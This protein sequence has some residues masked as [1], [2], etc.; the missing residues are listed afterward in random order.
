MRMN[1]E[2]AGQLHSNTIAVQDAQ[3]AHIWKLEKQVDGMGSVI[4]EMRKRQDTM[5]MVLEEC[6]HQSVMCQALLTHY[7]ESHWV[8]IGALLEQIG[9]RST[10]GL[11]PAAPHY[12]NLHDVKPIIM[13]ADGSPSPTS[14]PSLESV[15]SSSIDSVYYTPTFLWGLPTLSPI[16]LQ[17]GFVFVNQGGLASLTALPSTIPGNSGTFGDFDQQSFLEGGFTG[18]PLS[19]D[20]GWSAGGGGSNAVGTVGEGH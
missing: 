13:R 19:G 9:S 8:P 6:Q 10:C 1:E 5:A 11:F 16:P 7:V 20:E 14:L 15:S 3:A 17:E 4:H 12:C 2:V 18:V